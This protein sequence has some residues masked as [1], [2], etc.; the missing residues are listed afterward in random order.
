MG[1]YTVCHRGKEHLDAVAMSV[2]CKST[3]SVK[4]CFDGIIMARARRWLNHSD[5]DSVIGFI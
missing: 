3:V 2:S 1:C 4:E 5:S